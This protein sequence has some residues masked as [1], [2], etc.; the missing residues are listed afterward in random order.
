[1]SVDRV[2][3]C[4]WYSV[5]IILV[6]SLKLVVVGIKYCVLPTS[7]ISFNCYYLAIE[8]CYFTNSAQYTG[9]L[10]LHNNNTTYY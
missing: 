8:I 6:L 10:Q 4:S 2:E 9:V 3:F 5:V 7:H 1:M